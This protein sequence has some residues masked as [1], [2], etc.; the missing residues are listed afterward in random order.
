MEASIA[1]LPAQPPVLEVVHDRGR[2][3]LDQPPGWWP[4]VP[5]LKSYEAAG[6][7][8]LQVLVG[9]RELLCDERLLVTHANAL[10]DSVGLTG[11]ALIIHAPGELMAGTRDHDAQLRGALR[12]AAVA[13]AEMLVY[14]GL[15]IGVEHRQRR[16]RLALEER[17]LRRLAD[18]AGELGVP[19]AIEN[20]APSYPGC[21]LVAHCPRAV[22]EL[23]RRLDSRHVGM[24]L[25]VGHAHIVA[26]YAGRE[27][28]ELIEPVLGRVILFHVHDN[29]GARPAAARAGGIEPV[30]LDLHL[31]PGAGSVPWESLGSVLGAHSAPICLEVQASNRPPPATLATVMREVLGLGRRISGL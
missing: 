18:L 15:R 8:H 26:G 28:L 1:P 13:G 29:F 3:G 22:A 7:R 10:R 30:R 4:A 17:S 24:C 23:V 31:A 20:L 11:L 9:A 2:L 5:R 12:Y 21:E 19:I 16:R 14:H 27:L 6:F 25:D